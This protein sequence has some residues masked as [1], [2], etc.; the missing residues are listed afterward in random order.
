MM[1]NDDDDVLITS[2]KGFAVAHT[3]RGKLETLPQQAPPSSMLCST[4]TIGLK[5]GRNALE[6][7]Q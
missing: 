7:R 2:A 5:Q 3:T 6:H 4:S 1:V